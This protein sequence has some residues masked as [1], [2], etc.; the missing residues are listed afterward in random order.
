MMI[1]ECKRCLLKDM[2][3]QEY[4]RTVSEYVESLDESLR[5]PKE[6][7]ERRLSLCRECDCLI[8]GMCRLCGCFVEARLQKLPAIARGHPDDGKEAVFCPCRENR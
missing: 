7:Y 8:N 1:R 4:Y 5:A 6:E 3:T 2:D